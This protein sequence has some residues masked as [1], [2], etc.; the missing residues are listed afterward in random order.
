[1]WE[2]R[3]QAYDVVVVGAGT[4]GSAAGKYLSRAG[5]RVLV[6]GPAEPADGETAGQQASAPI[7]VPEDGARPVLDRPGQ[8]H[9]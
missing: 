4:F 7:A 3:L 2:V 5:A 6:V 8:E 1:M 9:E